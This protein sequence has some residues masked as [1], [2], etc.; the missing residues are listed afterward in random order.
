MINYKKITL[1]TLLVVTLIAIVI[2]TRY[3]TTNNPLNSYS[4]EVINGLNRNFDKLKF[5]EGVNDEYKAYAVGI[6][7][8]CFDPCLKN[9]IF[10]NVSIPRENC[11]EL[12]KCQTDGYIEVLG[13]ELVQAEHDKE[14]KLKLAKTLMVCRDKYK[15]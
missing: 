3:S 11:E 2:I 14:T 10:P 15:K 6:F 12:C 7:M 13:T 9:E 8:G 4:T 5:P 1:A